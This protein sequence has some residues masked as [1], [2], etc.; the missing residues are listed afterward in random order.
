VIKHGKERRCYV[1][2]VLRIGC[3]QR[4]IFTCTR[5]RCPEKRR[6]DNRTKVTARAGHD[7]DGGE[8]T[9]HLKNAACEVDAKPAFFGWPARRL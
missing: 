8:R 1:R 2:Y 9:R 6:R 5:I 7:V 3:Q 4:V